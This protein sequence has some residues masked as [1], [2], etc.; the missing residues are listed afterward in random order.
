MRLAVG[1]DVPHLSKSETSYVR[2]SA[3]DKLRTI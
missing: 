1:M 3:S 2:E